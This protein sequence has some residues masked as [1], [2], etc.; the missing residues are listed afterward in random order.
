MKNQVGYVA[1][2]ACALRNLAVKG[3]KVSEHRA[4]VWFKFE[5]IEE[6]IIDTFVLYIVIKVT[7]IKAN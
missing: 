3:Y 4:Y 7:N 1:R 6:N 5:E 2:S